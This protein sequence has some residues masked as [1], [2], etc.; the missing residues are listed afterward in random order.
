LGDSGAVEEQRLRELAG[1]DSRPGI[2]ETSA[3]P[4]ELTV[5]VP[6][7]KERPNVTVLLERLKTVLA[8]IAWEV[9]YVDDHSPDGTADAVREIAAIDRR[10]RVIERIGRRGLSSA[11][12]E[13][14]MTSSAPYIAVMDADLQ[15]D[16]TA[17]PEML[18][19]I[20]AEKLDVVIASRRMAGGSM[21]DFAKERVKLSDMGSRLSKLVCRCEVTDPMSG[22]FVVESRFFRTLVPRL[23]G[24]GFKILVDILA[25]SPIAPR[26]GE[27][28][29]RF[30]TRQL[31]ES[32]LD[33]N[34]QLEY[35]FLVVDK[36]V[37]KW[38]PTRFALFV[39]VGALG[40]VVHLAVL[41]PL[42]LNH[43]HHFPQAQLIATAVAMT[44]NFLLNNMVTF[45]D[46]RLRGWR[47]VTGLVTFYAACSLGAV[48]NVAFANLLIHQGIPWYVAG[49]AGT[50]IS[51]VWNYGVNAVLTWRRSRT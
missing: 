49:T 21:G 47:I 29:Y 8:H 10:V 32:K 2:G 22:F 39:L 31:G 34:V 11:C 15:H 14:M 37:G 30:R 44:F 33:V 26:V 43:R 42:Y 48:I 46:R 27:V 38:L 41:A 28:P 12:V 1:S 35:I 13:G 7:F 16:E 25:S 3:H 40:V 45:R 51:S 9:V 17:L 24:S 5:V 4:I 18:R 50:G 20:E 6:T 23:T 36:L 19:K